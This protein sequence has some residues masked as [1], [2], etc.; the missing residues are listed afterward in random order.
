[1]DNVLVLFQTDPTFRSE[2]EAILS[3]FKV[4]FNESADTSSID[5]ETARNTVVIFG[6]P[7]PDFLTL[8]PRL[9]SLCAC[10]FRL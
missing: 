9:R 6:N 2:L 5:A 4:I 1:M 7:K 8:C 3:G 10:R